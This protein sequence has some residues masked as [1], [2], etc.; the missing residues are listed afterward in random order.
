MKNQLKNVTLSAIVYL[1]SKAPVIHFSERS[2]L[3][4]K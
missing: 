1:D 3:L 4:E 2:S